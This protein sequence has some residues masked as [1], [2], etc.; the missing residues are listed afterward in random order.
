MNKSSNDPQHGPPGPLDIREVEKVIREE[1]DRHDKY[2]EFAQGQIAKDRSFYKYLY[3]GVAAFLTIMVAM[4]VSVS[5]TSVSQM[6]ADMKASVDAVVSQELA[7]V[8][9][10]VQ[11]R[12]DAEFQSENITRLVASAAKERTDIQISAIIRTEA[13]AQVAKGI[14]DQGPAIQKEVEDRT[15]Q[16]VQALQPTITEIVNRELEAEVKKSVT[17][18]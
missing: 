7:N 15:R 12:I 4:A 18:V 9:T 6:R 17:P 2:L 10:E 14:Q 8:R 1:L 16:A 5:Y 11:K 3:T 13:A